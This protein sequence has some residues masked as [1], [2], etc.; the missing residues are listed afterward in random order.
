MKNQVLEELKIEEKVVKN[1]RADTVDKPEHDHDPE[2]SL[3]QLNKVGAIY[4]KNKVEENIEDYVI[5]KIKKAIINPVTSMDVPPA[6]ANFRNHSDNPLRQRIDELTHKLE[7]GQYELKARPKDGCYF[8]N[9]FLGTDG[10]IDF[11]YNNAETVNEDEI[12]YQELEPRVTPNNYAFPPTVDISAYLHSHTDDLEQTKEDYID[13]VKKHAFSNIDDPKDI[14]LDEY[15]MS[16]AQEDAKNG[17]VLEKINESVYFETS[18]ITAD[19]I[20]QSDE[21]KI[22]ETFSPCE[23]EISEPDE[24][25]EERVELIDKVRSLNI[26][27]DNL[28]VDKCQNTELLQ[29]AD[30]LI[31]AAGKLKEMIGLPT[32][33]GSLRDQL[34]KIFKQTSKESCDE[35]DDQIYQY[36]MDNSDLEEEDINIKYRSDE[37]FKKMEEEEERAKISS[38]LR[39]SA[40]DMIIK[41]LMD[42]FE[43]I[44]IEKLD[45]LSS[46]QKRLGKV[47]ALKQDKFTEEV[48]IVRDDYQDDYKNDVTLMEEGENTEACEE[49]D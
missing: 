35:I 47:F 11:M 9:V 40:H 27:V 14:V 22:K 2:L 7:N 23:K 34:C 21:I 5:N 30:G 17:L 36:I 43:E 3:E 8:S 33:L 13:Y 38:E 16:K 24:I 44:P 10:K 45:N 31:D 6:R 20:V 49:N 18:E 26:I 39:N 29:I 15:F 12:D 1:K 42:V 37:F 19:K 32:D 46:D 48:D 4:N 25:D 28:D 41:N